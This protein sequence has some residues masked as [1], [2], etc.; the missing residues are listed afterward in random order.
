MKYRVAL[1]LLLFL[2]GCGK[3]SPKVSP[4]EIPTTDTLPYYNE[5]TFTP[6]WIDEK[7]PDYG[8][9]HTITDFTYTFETLI[10]AGRGRLQIANLVG[11][12]QGCQHRS[13]RV[14]R[15]YA[16]G[17]EPAAIECGSPP[18]HRFA[19]IDRIERP[20]EFSGKGDHRSQA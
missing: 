1:L 15:G 18:G 11:F 2:P 17:V 14:E 16:F 20:V 19:R 3:K 7:H 8:D 12:P 13:R 10:Q 9:L 5:K 6:L 4:A